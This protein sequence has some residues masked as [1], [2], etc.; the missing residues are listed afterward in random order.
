[1]WVSGDASK[2][3]RPTIG[4]YARTDKTEFVLKHWDFNNGWYRVRNGKAAVILARH[5]GQN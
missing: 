4:I 3:H 1:M 2:V 5:L